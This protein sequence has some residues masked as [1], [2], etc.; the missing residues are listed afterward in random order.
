MAFG[1]RYESTEYRPRSP[2]RRLERLRPVV[3]A[4]LEPR[5]E[6]ASVPGRQLRFSVRAMNTLIEDAISLARK[7]TI[8]HK[9]QFR[10]CA[11]GKRRDGLYVHSFNVQVGLKGCAARV[12]EKH[13]EAR[14]ATKLT[15]NSVVAV[16]RVLRDGTVANA[17]PCKSCQVRLR[18][19]GVTRVYYTIAPGECGVLQW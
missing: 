6:R 14:V 17:K 13:A 1:A 15:R 18:N 5:Q 7:H 4:R 11:I 2:R 19:M 3:G 12:P 9:K 10:L 16:A 8:R